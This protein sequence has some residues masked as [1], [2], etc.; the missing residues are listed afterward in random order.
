MYRVYT[1]YGKEISFFDEKAYV[2]WF[3]D[4]GPFFKEIHLNYVVGK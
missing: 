3:F 2:L 4:T 1:T